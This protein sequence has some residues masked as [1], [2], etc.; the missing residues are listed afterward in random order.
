MAQADQYG[1]VILTCEIDLD[2]PEKTKMM[3][4]RDRRV[5]LYETLLTKDGK[6]KIQK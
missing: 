3:R 6:T 4:F 5:D 2:S 1:E